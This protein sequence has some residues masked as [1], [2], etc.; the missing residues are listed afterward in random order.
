METHL[1]ESLAVG[2]VLPFVGILLSIALFPLFAGRFWHHHFPKISLFWALSLAVPFVWFYRG[3]AVHEIAHIFLVDYFP[4]VILLWALYTVS[5]GILLTGTLDGS[6]RQNT[7]IIASGTLL[8]S[9]IGTTGA[10]MVLVR[11]LLRAI[12]WRRHKA[13]VVVFFIF[14]VSNIGGALTPLGDPPL[15]LGFLHHVPFFWTL[16]LA[17]AMFFV[18]VPLLVVFYLIDRRHHA[19]EE[20]RPVGAAATMGIRGWQNFICLAG[21]VGAVLMSGMLKLGEVHVLGVEMKLEGLLRD[22]VLIAIGITSLKTTAP[23]I[24]RDNQ[25][26]W[27]PIK[28]VAILFAGIFMTIIP[29]LAILRAGEHGA[30]KPLI[31]LADH[32]RNYFWLAGRAFEFPRQRADVPDI[33]QYG[34]G[35]ARPGPARTRSRAAAHPFAWTLPA[36]DLV[37]CRV[38]GGEHLRRQR[39]Q[40]HGEEHRGG[41]RHRDAELFR[42]YVQV[43]DSVPDTAVLARDVRVLSIVRD[44]GRH[45]D[46]LR[47]RHQR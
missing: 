47:T 9:F 6:P 3:A 35:R 30:L 19:R 5:S 14:L 8:A 13:H 28:E 22:A 33:L 16:K 45:G 17:P 41:I 27:F 31:E 40:F 39:A 21:I 12:S 43:F 34:A 44:G 10:S 7:L 11:P 23:A 37:R 24:H 4:F 46:I 38:H 18:A 2:W 42:L 15:F 26:S 29:A 1:G 36:R 20:S 32:P 25:F